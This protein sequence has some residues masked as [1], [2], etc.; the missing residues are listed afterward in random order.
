MMAE[1]DEHKVEHLNDGLFGNKRSWIA[2]KS[3]KSPWFQIEL[4]KQSQVDMIVFGRDN[5]SAKIT[6]G[7]HPNHTGWNDRDIESF[8]IQVSS[9]GTNWSEPIH[10]DHSFAGLEAGQNYVIKLD[11]TISCKFVRMKFQPNTACIDE[12]EVFG[13]P[14]SEQSPFE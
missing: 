2:S 1:R 3:D 7:H 8:T 14:S 9:D 6:A 12:F 11:K 5:W 10:T 4:A 13:Q